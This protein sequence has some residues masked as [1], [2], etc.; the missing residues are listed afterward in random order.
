MHTDFGILG[1]FVH[2][3]GEMLEVKYSIGKNESISLVRT[4]LVR[5]H[6]VRTHLPQN[7]SYKL[8]IGQASSFDKTE[9]FRK[10]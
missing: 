4:H 7:R 2:G 3:F 1:N 9:G 8:P 6:L 5:T 10:L